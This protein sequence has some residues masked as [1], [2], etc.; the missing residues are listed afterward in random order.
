MPATRPAK[1]PP[2]A[3]PCLS[4]TPA[5]DLAWQHLLEA[6]TT[7]PPDTTHCSQLDIPF[8]DLPICQ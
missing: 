8:A 1:Q 6:L 4:A 3:E 7:P 2:P 5:L